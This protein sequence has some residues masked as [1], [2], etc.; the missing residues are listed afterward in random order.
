MLN[1]KGN[2]RI[3]Y[4]SFCLSVDISSSNNYTVPVVLCAQ[5]FLFWIHQC[6]H[7]KVNSKRFTKR[8][9]LIEDNCQIISA[10]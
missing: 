4:C 3:I 9:K 10:E 6:T 7:N 5:F 2:V 8:L 1:K